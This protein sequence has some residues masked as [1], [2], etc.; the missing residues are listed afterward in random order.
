VIQAVTPKE[1]NP[2]SGSPSAAVSSHML[3]VDELNWPRPVGV[4]AGS[5]TAVPVSQN[6][7]SR[8]NA[9]ERLGDIDL[10]DVEE[11]MRRQNLQQQQ[12]EDQRSHSFSTVHEVSPVLIA[13]D[14]SGSTNSWASAAPVGSGRPSAPTAS[15]PSVYLSTTVAATLSVSHIG[16]SPSSPSSSRTTANRTADST[17]ANGAAAAHSTG[18][19][20]SWT[21]VLTIL[22]DDASTRLVQGQP[23]DDRGLLRRMRRVII[24]AALAATLHVANYIIDV[25]FGTFTT[26]SGATGSLWAMTTSLIM[27]LAVPACGYCGVVHFNKQ[28]VCCFGGFNFLIVLLTIFSFIRLLVKVHELDGQ[29]ELETNTATRSQCVVWFADGVAK[30][31][32]L[33]HFALVVV[34]SC[35]GCIFASSLYSRMGEEPLESLQRPVVG[36]L[37]YLQQAERVDAAGNS[38]AGFAPGSARTTGGGAPVQMAMP[39]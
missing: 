21:E 15:S 10:L 17:A 13:A 22:P 3:S 6:S 24:I 18:G 34:I 19:A 26:E 9:D 12:Q 30:Y 5:S 11:T 4:S 2:P 33:V 25:L 14:G 35:P 28:L 29:C 38:A 32:L 8:T 39:A 20:N 37:V 7:H 36:E 1:S 27:E 31:L 23:F 16:G